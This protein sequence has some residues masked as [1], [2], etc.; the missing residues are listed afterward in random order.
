MK[1]QL[2]K[3][4]FCTHTQGQSIAVFLILKIWQYS[5]NYQFQLLNMC[6]FIMLS[7]VFETFYNKNWIALKKLPRELP[8]DFSSKYL[9]KRYENRDS[10][11][12]IP[13]FIE[14][15]FNVD[16]HQPYY[17]KQKS[18]NT[19]VHQ[20]KICGLP[21]GSHKKKNEVLIHILLLNLTSLKEP[22][23]LGEMVGFTPGLR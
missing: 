21:T 3:N 4:V 16:S 19:Q 7:S 1:L 23:I 10:D 12:S 18:G 11:I 13:V 14:S 17:S 22:G 2:F 15:L 20:Q 6:K 9:P 8:C 5:D